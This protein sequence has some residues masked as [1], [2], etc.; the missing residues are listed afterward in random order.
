ML[1]LV[2]TLGFIERSA[3]G[4]AIRTTP[5]LY[6]VLM[7]LPASHVPLGFAVVLCRGTAMLLAIALAVGESTAAPWKFGLI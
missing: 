6:P 5:N 3:L 1:M 7:S 4:E 2:D